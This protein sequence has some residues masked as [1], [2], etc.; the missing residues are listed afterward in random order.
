MLLFFNL[1]KVAGIVSFII[2]L[3]KNSDWK[4]SE[5]RRRLFLTELAYAMIRPHMKNRA[6]VLTLQSSARFSFWLCLNFMCWL[7]VHFDLSLCSRVSH[8]QC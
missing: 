1:V 4:A 5:G 3:A 8:A 6:M 2:R 7:Y